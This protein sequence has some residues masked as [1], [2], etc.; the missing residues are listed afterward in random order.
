MKKSK[1]TEFEKA[2]S[3]IDVETVTEFVHNYGTLMAYGFLGV[4]TILVIAYQFTRSRESHSFTDYMRADRVYHHFMQADLSE[5]PEAFEQ[6][7][8][9]MARY[10]DLKQK[11]EGKVA[12]VLIAKDRPEMARP[13][14][15][16]MI[17]RSEQEGFPTFLD[18]TKTT[19]LITEGEYD[20]A[21]Q[22]ALALQP[23]LQEED[24]LYAFNLLRLAILERQLGLL[25]PELE[26]WEQILAAADNNDAI[27]EMLTHVQEGQ[28][29]LNTYI[30]D[31]VS[32]LSWK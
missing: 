16:Q 18:Y 10:P 7:E 32:E 26:H 3:W 14:I 9:L 4:V 8:R 2:A 6:L 21:Y 17:K 23:Q 13:Y 11:Y 25:K 19:L 29:S 5:E 30:Q 27:K 15:D 20:D 1:K 22:Q 24:Q 31:R 12:Q 28:V